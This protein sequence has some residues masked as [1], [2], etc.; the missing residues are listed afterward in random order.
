LKILSTGYYDIQY[1]R[2]FTLIEGI[3]KNA[4]HEV[5]EL[6]WSEKNIIPEDLMD[7][8]KWCDI[9][10][11][12]PFT[13]ESI[14]K[15]RKLTKKPIVFDPLISNYMSKVY[16]FKK[17]S[18]Y[19][20]RAWKHFLKEKRQ[21]K[22][23]D[24]VI[25]DTNSHGLYLQKL[26]G[27]DPERMK[28]IYIGADLNTFY[29]NSAKETQEFHVGFYGSFIP[30][31]GPEVIIEAAR[32]LKDHS[33][34][35]FTLVGNGRLLPNVKLLSEKYNL[36]NVRFLDR[37]EYSELNN[38]INSFDV[39]LGIFGDSIKTNLV[40]ANKTYHYAACGKPI[41]TRDTDGVRELFRDRENILFSKGTANNLAER[42]LELHNAPDLAKTIASNALRLMQTNYS[43]EKIA[44]LFPE[45]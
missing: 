41:I 26:F 35:K 14:I 38:V 22:A 45:F 8:L 36:Q 30:L 7:M 44:N 40:I 1:N 13:H 11:L 39:C 20:P 15:V 2:N 31:Q 10:Y 23:A 18:K 28:T 33:N 32:N 17:Y 29:P 9:I 12:P 42:I 34:I 25:T 4:K 37:V 43:A 3:R 24:I 6:V 16:D 19:S 27:L 21:F 5:K